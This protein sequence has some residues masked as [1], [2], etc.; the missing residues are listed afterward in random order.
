MTTETQQLEY[1]PAA[2]M[3]RRKIRRRVVWVLLLLAAGYAGMQYGPQ[4]W[5]RTTFLYAQHRCLSYTAPANQLVYDEGTDTTEANLARA[6]FTRASASRQS[7]PPLVAAVRQA[8]PLVDFAANLP[9]GPSI[10]LLISGAVQWTPVLNRAQGVPVGATLF[11]HE[12]RNKAGHRRLVVVQ[13]MP[14]EVGPFVYPFALDVA[15]YAPAGWRRPIT[16][17]TKDPVPDHTAKMSGVNPL[18]PAHPL[19]FWA[20]QIDPA[21]PGHFTIRYELGGVGGIVDGWLNDAGDDVV[22]KIASG[23]AMRPSL[24]STYLARQP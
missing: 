3:R 2:P 7:H 21:D 13:R 10:T 4:A 8:R 14:R 11:C 1:A 9:P 5:R 17:V 24:W 16:N 6:G 23:P 22:I 12:L 15:L 18:I 20:G 19:R